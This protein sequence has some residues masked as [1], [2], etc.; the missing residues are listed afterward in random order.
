MFCVCCCVELRAGPDRWA[1]CADCGWPV[2][3]RDCAE[4]D[5]HRLECAAFQRANSKLPRGEYFMVIL[6]LLKSKNSYYTLYLV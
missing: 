6:T 2:C 5:N 4:K 3:R 1:Q